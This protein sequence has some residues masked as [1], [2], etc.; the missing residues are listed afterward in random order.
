MACQRYRPVAGGK[1]LGNRQS[2]APSSRID[3]LPQTGC[4]TSGGSRIWIESRLDARNREQQRLFSHR[5]PG[6]ASGGTQQCHTCDL[7]R[8]IR[9]SPATGVPAQSFD[10]HWLHEVR[11]GNHGTRCRPRLMHKKILGNGGNAEWW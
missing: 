1:A 4:R 5:E 6:L 10:R 7:N 3:E 2:I 9:I 11:V 8:K